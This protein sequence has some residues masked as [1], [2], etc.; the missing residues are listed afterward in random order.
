MPQ[1]VLD[2]YVCTK[3]QKQGIGRRIFEYMLEVESKRERYNE[4]R[5]NPARFAYD[6]PSHKLLSFLKKYYNLSSYIP[7]NNNFVVFRKY[8]DL[9]PLIPSSS[10]T[11]IR[12]S[13]PPPRDTIQPSPPAHEAN[14]SRLDAQLN[15]GMNERVERQQMQMQQGQGQQRPSDSPPPPQRFSARSNLSAHGAGILAIGGGERDG[16]RGAGEIVAAGGY[17]SRVEREQ[18]RAAGGVAGALNQQS[19]LPSSSSSSA[20]RINSRV[21][22]AAPVPIRT[23]SASNREA[24]KLSIAAPQSPPP[25]SPSSHHYSPA[26]Y[27]HDYNNSPSRIMQRKHTADG[28]TIYHSHNIVTGRENAPI[29]SMSISHPPARTEEKSAPP[30]STHTAITTTSNS[31]RGNGIPPYIRGRLDPATVAA[32]PA[33]GFPTGAARASAEVAAARAN[34]NLVAATAAYHAAPTTNTNPDAQTSNVPI[35]GR[36][37]N[38]ADVNIKP[39]NPPGASHDALSL[40]KQAAAYSNAQIAHYQ[41]QIDADKATLA[42]PRNF[43]PQPYSVAAPHAAYYSK[44]A[45]YNKIVHGQGG[46]IVD[47]EQVHSDTDPIVQAHQYV[48]QELYGQ[49]D[50][51]QARKPSDHSAFAYGTRRR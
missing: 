39:Y 42:K 28:L 16:M 3:L 50:P 44:T 20:S 36:R 43:E 29:Q 23:S 48:Q 12:S 33:A 10:N 5:L 15:K 41:S 22:S 19:N 6:R 17:G 46:N 35:A 4:T 9:P 8:W 45:S 51:I 47:R 26:D 32:M 37:A 13:S 27:P 30:P 14:W 18:Q 34:S 1:C 24:G 7:Q 2:F 40:S 31:N 38:R 49:A 11:A 21:P 25:T